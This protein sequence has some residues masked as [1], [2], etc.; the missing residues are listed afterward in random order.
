MVL[1]RS[2]PSPVLLI[3]MAA[4]ISLPVFVSLLLLI[5]MVSIAAE[6]IEYTLDDYKNRST[7]T[8]TTAAVTICSKQLHHHPQM[9]T[10]SSI[11]SSTD[12]SRSDGDDE[13]SISPDSN[14]KKEQRKTSKVLA[15]LS[16]ERLLGS[17]RKE[18]P[19]AK[20]SHSHY[21]RHSPERSSQELFPPA[22]LP[23]SRQYSYRTAAAPT[24]LFGTL[25]P[26]DNEDD[27]FFDA[28]QNGDASKDSF[29]SD[30]ARDSVLLL[31][32]VVPSSAD[33]ESIEVSVDGVNDCA[34]ASRKD[35]PT[36]I[37]L[38]A[39]DSVCHGSHVVNGAPP[40]PPPPTQK[41]LLL[42]A[43]IPSP[44]APPA[45]LPLR[46]L[47]AGKGDASVGYQ[48][49]QETLAWRRDNA[50][51]TILHQPMP[52]FAL[53]KQ[54]YPHFCHGTGKRGEPCFYEQPPKTN[55]KALREG[56]VTLDKLLRHY[57]MVSEYQWQFVCRDDLQ[58][59]IY[60]IDLQGIRMGDFVGEVVDFVKKASALSAMHYPER[61]GSVFVINVP[62]WFRFIWSVVKPWVDESTLQKIFILRGEAEVRNA[63][64]ERI[65]LEHIPTE[66]GGTGGRLGES[67]EEKTLWE[68]SQHNNAI[69]NGQQT[70]AGV[71]G[72]CRF[73]TWLP[74]RSY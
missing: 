14:S 62:S 52:D 5:V 51:D 17:G 71:Q 28:Q 19:N 54:H 30:Y 61:A 66:Y 8:R 20:K 49:Y 12:S 26:D 33:N 57:A 21:S 72:G 67:P 3:L 59:S 40:P 55:L 60:I 18:K 70:C 58:R 69:A 24:V 74:P 53:I 10:S 35:S 44:P 38:R 2:H 36:W 25:D 23:N 13:D 15:A 45:Q 7:T 27:V 39:G 41:H 50:I 4:W 1:R 16:F 11:S 37:N 48:R 65:E 46:F 29:K 73:C 43:I 9:T 34:T 22:S 68:W 32:S 6:K 31:A 42:A 64:M 56:G 47:R 63:L